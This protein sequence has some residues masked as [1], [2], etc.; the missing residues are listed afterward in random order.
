VA[1]YPVIKIKGGTEVTLPAEAYPRELL[2]TT[3]T[4]NLYVGKGTGTSTPPVLVADSTVPARVTS[5]EN[6]LATFYASNSDTFDDS[7]KVAS[8]DSEIAVIGGKVRPTLINKYTENA[9]SSLSIDTQYSKN[10]ST[11]SNQIK[12][13]SSTT[14][15]VPFGY[16]GT[17]GGSIEGQYQT[18]AFT[19]PSSTNFTLTPTFTGTSTASSGEF[20]AYTQS[21]YSVFN[22][23]I[24]AEHLTDVDGVFAHSETYDFVVATL[25]Y[26][27]ATASPATN[28]CK[29]KLKYMKRFFVT[30]EEA[31]TIADFEETLTSYS[32]QLNTDTTVRNIAVTIVDNYFYVAIPHYFVNSSTNLIIV[33]RY[34]FNEGTNTIS[35]SGVSWMPP[36]PT[37]VTPTT[38]HTVLGCD[39][40]NREGRIHLIYNYRRGASGTITSTEYAYTTSATFGTTGGSVEFF[41]FNASEDTYNA[42]LCAIPGDALRRVGW[43]VSTRKSTTAMT[44]GIIDGA[45]NTS[46]FQ[47]RTVSQVVAGITQVVGAHTLSVSA[48]GTCDLIYDG[49]RGQFYGIFNAT[50]G[51]DIDSF[52]ISDTTTAVA[53]NRSSITS[54][55]YSTLGNRA[56]RGCIKK[57]SVSGETSIHIIFTN[58]TRTT[59][60]KNEF[61]MYNSSNVAVFTANANE[62]LTLYT[63]GTGQIKQFVVLPSRPDITSTSFEHPKTFFNIGTRT[64]FVDQRYSIKTRLYASL[65]D[66]SYNTVGAEILLTSSNIGYGFA[67]TSTTSAGIRFRFVLPVYYNS[68]N[69]PTMLSSSLTEYIIEQ[70]STPSSGGFGEF[71][72][73][74]LIQDRLIKNVSL[75]STQALGTTTG[76]QIQWYAQVLADVGDTWYEIYPDTPFNFPEVGWGSQLRLKGKLTYGD[77]VT[78][79]NSLPS[80]DFYN[81]QVSSVLTVNDLLPLQINLM[82]MGINVNTLATAQR[83][84]YNNMMIDTFSTNAGYSTVG[85]TPQLVN[86]TLTNIGATNMFVTTVVE[87]AD[88]DNVS[89]IICLWEGSTSNSPNNLTVSL[90]SE[91]DYYIIDKEVVFTFPTVGNQIR[92]RITV[93]PNGELY[94]W[95]YLYK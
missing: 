13:I 21:P 26:Q 70:T 66:A 43:L 40:L 69:N 92:M 46:P 93:P 4:N 39:I 68:A 59:L 51:G 14:D 94:G 49:V 9:N 23:A 67:T 2:I 48:N 82:K 1:D 86:G 60:Y 3:D 76:N 65:I 22:S 11:A 35:Y 57:S 44:F 19:F 15:T 6:Q 41:R 73:T 28:T 52:S 78:D 32:F 38:A 33:R 61:L 25:E 34:A 16:D 95:S 12:E 74:I 7:D 29:L 85:G 56:I 64:L 50:S 89:N 54:T 75:T 20:S 84:S 63:G 45:S 42:R 77:G 47:Y 71:I 37:G 17:T 55:P 62:L 30:D 87:T 27:T 91:S 83:L 88:I 36:I 8:I 79:I 31:R 80:I 5:I 58:S 24:D 90:N 18:R 53:V 72:S 81:V 10:I